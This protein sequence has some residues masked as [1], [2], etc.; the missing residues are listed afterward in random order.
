MRKGRLAAL[1][2]LAS[3]FLGVGLFAYQTL[4]SNNTGS[5]PIHFIAFGAGSVAYAY[6][7]LREA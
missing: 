3:I 6:F 2:G 1:I 4:S 5:A 7:F